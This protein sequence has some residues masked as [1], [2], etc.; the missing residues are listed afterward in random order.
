MPPGKAD[1]LTRDGEHVNQAFNL[2]GFAEQMLVHEH[3]LVKI[4]EDM[5]LDRAALIGCSV[6][7]GTGAVFRSARVEPGSTVAVV[8]CGGVGLSCIMGAAMAGALRIV[9]I[10]KL[11]MKLDMA[12]TFGATDVIDAGAG[13][14]VD[15]VLSLLGGVDYSFEC[16]GAK[17]TAEQSF[18]MLKSGGTATILGVMPPEMTLEIPGRQFLRQKRIQGSLMGSNHFTVDIPRLVD[19]YLQGRLPLDQMISQRLPLGRINEGFADLASG[20][21]ARSVIIFP[22]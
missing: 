12:K 15:Q 21:V 20:S 2:S 7:T 1:R 13:D 22:S 8:G 18:A 11:P 14:P 4:R 3:A 5:P 10:D 17:K 19:F 6:L 16:I 9:A